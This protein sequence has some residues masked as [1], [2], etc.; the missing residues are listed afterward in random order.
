MLGAPRMLLIGASGQVGSELMKVLPALGTALPASRTSYEFP[1]E[2]TEPTSIRAVIRAARPNIIINAA[3]YTATD[4]AES[5]TVTARAINCDALATIGGEASRLNVPVVHFST[6]YVFDG[7]SNAPYRE[8]DRCAPLNVYGQSKLDGEKVLAACGA[9]HLIFRTSWV[10]GL[11]GNNFLNTVLALAQ[12]EK[13]L[14]IVDDQIGAPTWS[15]LIAEVTASV[16]RKLGV[17]GADYARYSG[18]YH[19]TNSGYTSW[20]GFAQRIVRLTRDII[21]HVADEI[22]PIKSRDFARSARRPRNS[23]LDTSKICTTFG[24]QLPVWEESLRQ[25]LSELATLRQMAV[26]PH[27]SEQRR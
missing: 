19:L 9:A 11:G 8:Q 27:Q 13:R 12:T 6:D 16:I 5:D 15:R 26:R 24:V 25:C 14:T 1:L 17:L 4:R 21:P 22:V 10:Y 23:R 7:A 18:V 2:L 3:A 20:Y